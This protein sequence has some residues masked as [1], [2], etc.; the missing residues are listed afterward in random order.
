MGLVY[1]TRHFKQHMK[2]RVLTLGSMPLAIAFSIIS[3][4]NLEIIPNFP[5]I[6]FLVTFGF[7]LEVLIFTVAFTYWYRSVEDERE[8]LKLK[9][10]IE[11][12]EK[13]IAVQAAE[14]RVKDRIARDLHDDVAASLSSIRIL[15]QVAKSRFEQL[16]PDAAQLLQQINRSAQ[17]TLDEIGDIIWAIKPHPDY[18]NDMADRMREYAT[19]ML[20]ARDLDYHIDIPRNLPALELDVEARRNIYLIF[21]EA[22]NNILKHSQC[23]HIE[24]G[25]IAEPNQLV[26]RVEDNGIGFDTETV[27]R[28]HGLGNM[29]SRA[30]DIRGNLSIE[31]T[32][33]QGTKVL[34]VLPL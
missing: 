22:I 25:L 12:G 9:I 17:S 21:K 3:L 16:S 6:Q 8:K 23:T 34:F 13:V 26:L 1:S 20:D 29:A 5:L 19:R 28:G 2:A 31:A 14:Q 30:N 7:I 15:S 32:P 33:D 18:L 27:R 24:I 11:Q 4:R 10:Q